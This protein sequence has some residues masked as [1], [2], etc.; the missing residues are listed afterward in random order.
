MRFGQADF[1]FSFSVALILIAF[2]I[3]AFRMKRK[4]YEK[5][6]QKE[7]LEELLVFTDVNKQ[8]FKAG[9]LLTAAILI[10][11]SLMRPQWGFHWQEVKRRGLDIIIALD[12]SKSMLAQDVK[13]SRLERSKLAIRDF[14]KNLK[15]DRIGLVA[16]SGTAFL[17]CPL[18]V[19]YGGFLLSLDSIDTNTI[20]RGGTSLASAIKEAV[21]GYGSQEKK[22]K[23]LVVITDGENNEGD[24]FAAA[25]EAKKNGIII[26]CIGIGT[27][28]GELISLVQEGGQQQFLK[29]QEG[30]VVKTRLDEGTLEKI[31]LITGGSY[32]RST[33]AEF[34]LELLYRER[35]SKMERRELEGKMN[36][37]YI[38]RFQVPLA[39]ALFLILLEA[40]ISDRKQ[41]R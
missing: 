14:I 38:E 33:A 30:N 34:G 25:E 11:F 15:G 31:A 1:I 18:T 13:P 16:F 9:L 12:T 20:P 28:E 41:A 27:K 32:I 17:E 6:A 39:V 7:L 23:A 19:D 3:W 36:K 29:D 35:L 37:R 2:C 10:I 40:A 22:Y 4:A 8:K 5:F 26:F 21:K 24:P